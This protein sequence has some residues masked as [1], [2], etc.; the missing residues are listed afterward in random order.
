MRN[1]TITVDEEVAGWA[2]VW[3]ARH[4]S[5]VSRLVGELLKERM[6]R[7]EGYPMAMNQYLATAPRALKETGPYPSREE[8]HDRQGIRRH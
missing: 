3:A 1:I 6:L 8:F 2:K 4:D 5:S 7:E